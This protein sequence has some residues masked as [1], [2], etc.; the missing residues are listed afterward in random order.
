MAETKKKNMFA[1]VAMATATANGQWIVDG[2][3]LLAARLYKYGQMYS[4]LVFVAEHV[5]V[6]SAPVS[7]GWALNGVP[8]ES[9]TPGAVPVVPKQPG[10]TVSFTAQID[11]PNIPNAVGNMKA[12]FLALCNQTEAQFDEAERTAMRLRV[13]EHAQ[14]IAAKKIGEDVEHD[15]VPLHLLTE[16]ARSPFA[17][18]CAFAI[19]PAQPLRGALIRCRTVRKKNQGRFRPENKDKILV[20]HSWSHVDL[21]VAV[22]Q[23]L[24]AQIDAGQVPTLP[25]QPGAAAQ[26]GTATAA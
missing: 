24:R 15:D 21:D 18:Y 25:A 14:L 7:E 22:M 17:V 13:Q 6:W 12:Y 9:G 20:M 11:N 3:Y 10:E 5:V 4:G 19:G 16:A 8:C 26:P 1:R 23:H 2:D